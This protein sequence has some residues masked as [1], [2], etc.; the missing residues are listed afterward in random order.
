MEATLQNVEATIKL[1]FKSSKR[2]KYLIDLGSI[3]CLW[4]N[5]EGHECNFPR[6]A[7]RAN[8]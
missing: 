2:R 4:M 3:G 6:V 8:K 7:S 1:R 5:F